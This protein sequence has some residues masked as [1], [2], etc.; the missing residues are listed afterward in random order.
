M[1]STQSRATRLSKV[2]TEVRK[3]DEFGGCDL[4]ELTVWWVAKDPHSC[5]HR[6]AEPLKTRRRKEL[7]GHT[8]PDDTAP[9]M[10]DMDDTPQVKGG[11]GRRLGDVRRDC[12]EEEGLQDVVGGLEMFAGIAEKKKDYRNKVSWHNGPAA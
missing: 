6:S 7:A 11:C 10:A 12:R 4:R 9:S 3:S 5:H 8:G 1:P 2:L